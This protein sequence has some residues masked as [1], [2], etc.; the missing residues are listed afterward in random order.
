VGCDDQKSDSYGSVG[1]ARPP[2]PE[3]PEGLEAEAQRLLDRA[4][5][6]RDQRC[7]EPEG[8]V[9]VVWTSD[10]SK[11]TLAAVRHPRTRRWLVAGLSELAAWAEMKERHPAIARGDFQVITWRRGEER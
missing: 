1:A 2:A 3:T 5:N 7:R 10:I 6:L 4:A 11:V 8:D 9:V